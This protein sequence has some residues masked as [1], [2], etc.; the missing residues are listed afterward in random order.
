MDRH[1]GLR[2]WISPDGDF[3]EIL[4][5]CPIQLD[6]RDFTGRN[7]TREAGMRGFFAERE[8]AL[9]DFANP[10]LLR[11]SLGHAGLRALLLLTFH[12]LTGNG[13]S[14]TMLLDELA[15]AYDA[16][17]GGSTPQLPPALQLHDFVAWRTEQDANQEESTQFWLAQFQDSVPVLDLP[18]DHPRPAMQT[19]RGGRQILVLDEPLMKSIKA[20]AA[21]QRCSLFMLL[22]GAYGVLLH[23]LTGQVERRHRRRRGRGNPH[24]RRGAASFREYHAHDAAALPH[25][26][27]T[28]PDQIRASKR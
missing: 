1:E 24:R 2:A 15:A 16:F 12:H 28:I 21:K 25:R 14:Y 9:F 6:L 3:Q 11:A 7:G 17:A 19:F 5:E 22:F 27:P 8:A 23:R 4:S 20:A 18:V 10:P 13:P 26:S